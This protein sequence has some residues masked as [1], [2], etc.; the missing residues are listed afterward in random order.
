VVVAASFIAVAARMSLVQFLGIY[1]VHRAGIDVTT[2]GLAFLCENVARGL[3]APPFG[4]LSDRIGRRPLLI[5]SSLV[6]ALVL[7]AF[8]LVHDPVAL[9]A[10]SLALGTAGAIN[11][12]VS[13]ALLLDLAPPARRQS[14]LALNY[15]TMS[16]A[17]TL[18][19]VPAGYIAERGY[20]ILAAA[21]AGG[22]LLVAALYLAALRGPL[23]L[24]K[25]AAAPGVLR[26]TRAAFADRRFALFAAIAFVFP[27]SMGML[28]TVTPLYATAR[29]L[30][31]SYIG[32]VLGANSILVAVLALPVATRI[33]AQGPFRLL[34][35]GAAIIALALACFALVPGAAAALLV[36][37]VIYSF[38][39]VVFSSAVPAGVAR[40]AP[41]GR[42]G[43]YQGAWTLVSSLSL[44]SALALSGAIAKPFGW[45]SA[46]LACAALTLAAALALHLL[47]GRFASVS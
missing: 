4:A 11:I 9:F 28:V 19:V 7:P 40:L 14:V 36:G 13:S 3:A 41:A 12:P 30:G 8:V 25:S 15:T 35:A 17:Y 33:E 37:T 21:S 38:G 32:L 34:G 46:W 18:G 24:E 10:W 6:T 5:G 23:P 47:R 29:G 42:R 1:F 44:G 27:L 31:E 16:I 45:P 20:G 26:D 22:Y 43:A 39:E 2:V